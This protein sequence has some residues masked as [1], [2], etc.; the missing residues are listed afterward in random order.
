MKRPFKVALF[1]TR[2]NQAKYLSNPHFKG[3]QSIKIFAEADAVQ[4][5]GT[6]FRNEYESN[7][8]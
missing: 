6:M 4:F 5:I 1:T 7:R 8:R 2:E 3:I